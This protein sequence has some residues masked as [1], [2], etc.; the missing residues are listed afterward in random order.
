[1]PNLPV[2]LKVV[3]CPGLGNSV[4]IKTGSVATLLSW[5]QYN[6]CH[7]VSFVMNISG[8]KLKKLGG[9]KL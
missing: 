4:L 3:C 6:R 9:K 2:H 1:M 8:A 5:Q 7:F